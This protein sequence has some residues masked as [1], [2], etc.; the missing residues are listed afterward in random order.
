MEVE[1]L[2]LIRNCVGMTVYTAGI[3]FAVEAG[4]TISGPI[5]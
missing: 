2:E 4:R 5:L 1:E 3:D